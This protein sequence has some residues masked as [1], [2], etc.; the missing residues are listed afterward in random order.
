VTSP[1]RDSEAAFLQATLSAPDD[2]TPRLVYADWLEEHGRSERAAFIR[3]QCELARLTDDDPR[4]PELEAMGRQLLS[5]HRGE[6]LGALLR[7]LNGIPWLER[8]G[9]P[10]A[11]DAE[12]YRLRG[13]DDWPGPEDV[14]VRPLYEFSQACYDRPLE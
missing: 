6:W 9:Q 14:D 11:R 5:A 7:L 3:L 10:S 8:L 1:G 13:W 12:V 2:D 4:R